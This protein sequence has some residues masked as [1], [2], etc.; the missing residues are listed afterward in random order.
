MTEYATKFVEYKFS[1]NESPGKIFEK[2]NSICNRNILL[3][4]RILIN[5]TPKNNDESKNLSLMFSKTINEPLIENIEVEKL[6]NYTL[7][8][9]FFKKALTFLKYAHMTKPE[10]FQR[11][12]QI[13]PKEIPSKKKM[14][15]YNRKIKAYGENLPTVPEFRK[16][17]ATWYDF[18]AFT[19]L[20]CDY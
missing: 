6:D 7:L 18:L 14:N 20:H 8:L 17:D 2:I 10:I 11:A 19:I 4:L 15:F 3:V 16:K 5:V 13:L 9:L 12:L 1:I